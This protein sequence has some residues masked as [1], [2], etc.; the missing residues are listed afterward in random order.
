MIYCHDILADT[1]SSEFNVTWSRTHPVVVSMGDDAY[2]TYL[3]LECDHNMGMTPVGTLTNMTWFNYACSS[4]ISIIEYG[5]MKNL[6]FD[7]QFTTIT[8]GS[9]SSV[10]R[11][12]LNAFWTGTSMEI[13]DTGPDTLHTL[14][15]LMFSKVTSSPLPLK[16]SPIYV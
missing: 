2:Q 16:I 6:E 14:H 11:D 7:Y 1:A 15:S 9:V 12:M 3:T 8:D 10:T 13:L 4:S 5:I